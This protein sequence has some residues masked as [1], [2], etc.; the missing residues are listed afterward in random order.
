MSTT[1]EKV[2]ATLGKRYA[3]EKRFR[4]YGLTAIALSILFLVI[5]L[6]DIIGKGYPAFTSTYI[7]LDVQL[8]AQTLGVTADPTPEQLRTANYNTVIQNSLNT[9]IPGVEDRKE[10]KA[11]KGLVSGD[12]Q[13]ELQRQVMANPALI[14]TSQ[15]VWVLAD[16]DIDTYYKGNVD[17]TLPEADRRIKDFQLAWLDKLEADGRIDSQFNTILFTR[18]DSR[19]P[20]E[21]GILS[22][23]I[24]S[25]YTLLVTLALSFPIGVA[26]AIYLEEFAPK[27]NFW[28]DLIEV[29]INNLAAVPS[30]VFGLLGLAV[31][32]QLF[33]MPRSAP[34][35]G[36]LVL[37]LM[38]LP[39][40]I[41]ATRAAL[42]AVPP[43]IREG[44]LGIGASKSQTVF[45][46]V[47]PLAMPGILTGTI[48]GMAQAL[49]ETAPL[50][51]IGMVAFIMDVPSSVT[52][53]S[54]VL[55]VQIFLWSDSPE[56]AFI[57]RTSAAIM[58][59]LA[60]LVSMNLLAVILRKRFERR[61]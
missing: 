51:M 23:L 42:R 47:L 50:L 2:K 17:R 57:E 10:K 35:V 20:E 27:N 25:F 49:G 26:A 48:I 1:T 3:R 45:Q 12:A 18:G 53:P 39:T 36:G 41:I 61:W 14:G 33:G 16:D 31:F 15:S 13:Y 29:N 24:G 56:R 7:K 32:I 52:S 19:E 43:S 22:A 11:L 60:F 44:A 34:L 5:L 55:P 30:I 59:L 46:N 40:I 38:T 9:L 37:T 21:A 8:D 54:T 6:T 28:V 58:V 4:F